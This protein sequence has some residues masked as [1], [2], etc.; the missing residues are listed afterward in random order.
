MIAL[1]AFYMTGFFEYLPHCVH[2]VQVAGLY[3]QETGIDWVTTELNNTHFISSI[4]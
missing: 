1:L 2:G 3:A 4:K